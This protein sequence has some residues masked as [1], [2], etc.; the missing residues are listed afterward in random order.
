MNIAVSLDSDPAWDRASRALAGVG[1]F[2]LSEFRGRGVPI[3]PVLSSMQF[4]AAA[5]PLCLADEVAFL[6]ITALQSHCIDER[7]ALL[8]IVGRTLSAMAP[9]VFH[10][11]RLIPDNVDVR[12]RTWSLE[13]LVYP[14]V[15]MAAAG[16]PGAAN[17]LPLLEATLGGVYSRSKS[18]TLADSRVEGDRGSAGNEHLRL[19]SPVAL[20]IRRLGVLDGDQQAMVVACMGLKQRA[21]DLRGSNGGVTDAGRD[22]SAVADLECGLCLLAPLLLRPHEQTHEAVCTVLE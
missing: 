20:G 15:S 22:A 1:I 10:D 13:T 5:D 18:E 12:V 2:L 3:T 19:S 14:L 8:D 4:L 16:N 21:S 17:V 9:H 11:S 6:G 7:E